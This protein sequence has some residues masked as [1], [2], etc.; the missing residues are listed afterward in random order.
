[1][2]IHKCD[3]E[4]IYFTMD[5]GA[6]GSISRKDIRKLCLVNTWVAKAKVDPRTDE[7]LSVPAGKL[8]DDYM[9]EELGI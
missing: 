1:M 4:R 8:A 3:G 5:S 7:C 2:K 6:N 9:F